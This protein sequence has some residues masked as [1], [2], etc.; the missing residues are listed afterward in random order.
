[1]K[2]FIES[3]DQG[4]WDEI[5]YTPKHVVDNRQVDKPC[6][7]WAEEEIRRAQYDYTT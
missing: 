3:I 5:F 1:M 2:I 6:T 4:I 7:E